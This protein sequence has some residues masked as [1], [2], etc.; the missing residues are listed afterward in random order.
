M[1]YFSLFLAG[2]IIILTP[3]PVFIASISLIA[4]RGRIEGL[5]LISGAL[6]GDSV[7]LFL[8]FLFFI[9]ANRL[10]DTFFPILAIAC[11]L[12]IFYLGYKLFKHAKDID[13]N[14]V[15]NKPFK[16][17]LMVGL[18]NPKTYPVNIAIFSA[19]VFEYLDSMTWA[20]FP[21]V[22]LFATLGFLS[23]YLFINFT[24]GFTF[25][26]DFYK[27]HISYFS[28]LFSAVFVYFGLTLLKEAFL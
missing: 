16:D 11:A 7:W 9:E 15:F 26:K 2:T 12:Y 19:L 17:G 22:F 13:Q 18:L 20:D 3:G 23:G 14:K 6:L 28:Y 10:P 4:E 25:I 21:I 8:T 1:L 5:K 24:A 27:K